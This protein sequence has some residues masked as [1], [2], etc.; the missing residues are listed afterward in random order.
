MAEKRDHTLRYADERPARVEVN[1][2]DGTVTRPCAN[3]LTC[4]TC[5]LTVVHYDNG[6]RFPGAAHGFDLNSLVIARRLPAC[7]PREKAP[8]G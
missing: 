7:E 1:T 2:P 8:H 5:G 3:L 4:E 6:G